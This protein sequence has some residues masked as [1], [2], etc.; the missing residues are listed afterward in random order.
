VI[1]ALDSVSSGYSGVPIVRD[2]TL[3]LAAG[4][5]LGIVGRNGVGKTTL[6]KTI[7]GLLRPMSGRIGFKGNDVTSADARDMA[8]AGMGYVPQGRGIFARLTVLE[9]LRMGEMIGSP[10]GARDYERVFEWFPRL[11]ERS[12]QRAGTLSGGEQ[13]MLALGRVLIG[14]PAFLLLDE[15][16]EGIQ[17]SIVQQIA[18]VLLQQNER[19]GLAVLLVEQ[20][21]DLVFMA[22]DRCLVM[23]KG[24]FV[25]ALTPEELADPDIAKRYLAI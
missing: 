22:A 13:Q 8:R 4:E 7:A 21:L 19:R 12:G 3:S 16:S 17:P 2:A 9:N 5:I 14:D 24:A 25:A 6:V 15:P 18:E 10:Q 1:L 20:N 23:D 11:R